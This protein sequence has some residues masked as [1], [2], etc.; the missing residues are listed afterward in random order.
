MAAI[1]KIVAAVWTADTAAAATDSTVY[2]CVAGREFKLETDGN[3]FERGAYTEYVL[4]EGTNVLDSQYNDPRIPQLDTDDLGHY[5]VY[6]RMEPSGSGPDWHLER[7]KVTVQPGGH[8]F[9]NPVL[10]N[11]AENRR[12]WLGQKPGKILYLRRVSIQG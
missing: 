6:V 8:T 2:L 3:D 1:T 10:E 4:G 12:I 7:I 11:Q 9:D 5:P